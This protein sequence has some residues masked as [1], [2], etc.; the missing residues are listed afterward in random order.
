MT[1]L[2]IGLGLALLLLAAGL[3]L[4]FGSPRERE[5]DDSDEARGIGA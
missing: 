5:P 1:A 4:F 3:I 2:Y